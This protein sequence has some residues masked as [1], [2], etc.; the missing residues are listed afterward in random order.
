M[1]ADGT[2]SVK[3][4]VPADVAPEP[5]ITTGLPV[6]LARMEKQYEG[7]VS[8]RSATL[9]TAAF[10]QERHRHL[11]GH[12]VVRGI[13]ERPGRQLQLRALGHTSGRDRA[14]EFF[15]IVPAS[16]TGDL[17]GITG[18]G[19]PQIDPDG[20]NRIWFDYSPG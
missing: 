11:R 6:G 12:G 14:A 18:G 3:S 2:F 13:A 16:G 8:G 7:E 10:S 19:G 15:V 5:P 4:F 20:T 9:L 1:R 17:A